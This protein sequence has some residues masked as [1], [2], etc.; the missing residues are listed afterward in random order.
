MKIKMLRVIGDFDLVVMQVKGHFAVK[1]VRLKRYKHAMIDSIEYFD[2]F[3]IEVVDR[4]LMF[5][6]MF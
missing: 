5:K 1:N 6:L 2:A 3:N 4:N